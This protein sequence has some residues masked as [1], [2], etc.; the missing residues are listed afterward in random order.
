MS[1]NFNHHPISSYQ[2]KSLYE[3]PDLL[4]SSPADDFV[5][6][7]PFIL[8]LK[9]IYML[10]VQ[11]GN[12]TIRTCVGPL[13]RFYLATNAPLPTD[14]DWQMQDEFLAQLF[15]DYYLE[16]KLKNHDN[17]VEAARKAGR[18]EQLPKT[19]LN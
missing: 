6:R 13:R 3:P 18:L 19:L 12:S 8:L 4:Q 11:R 14:D 15:Q 17:L 7:F 2:D 1:D 9:A 5:Y 10:R 16:R